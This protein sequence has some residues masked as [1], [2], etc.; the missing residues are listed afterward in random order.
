MRRLLLEGL[1]AP[2]GD[3]LERN[4]PG[5]LPS[6]GGLGEGVAGALGRGDGVVRL[7]R[8]RRVGWFLGM[9][10]DVESLGAGAVVPHVFWFLL[11][12][13]VCDELV[14]AE[15]N[16]SV[17]LWSRGWCHIWGGTPPHSVLETLRLRSGR[18]EFPALGDGFRLS[19]AG[20]TDGGG[21]GLTPRR[22]SS[23]WAPPARPFEGL[24]VSGPSPLDSRSGYGN[25]GG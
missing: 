13:R 12:F 3:L 4:E 18:T 7:S 16:T 10:L 15:Y 8:G 14:E 11:G 25:D 9:G 17:L 22:I 20:M 21:V 24:R 2:R 23:A 1:H 19:A 6:P 5:R